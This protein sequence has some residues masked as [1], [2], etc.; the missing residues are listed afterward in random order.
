MT[1]IDP[2]RTLE[3]MRGEDLRAVVFDLGGVLI[4]YRGAAKL[5]D[6]RPDLTHEESWRLW[7]SSPAVRAFETGRLGASEFAASLTA[8]LRLTVSPADFLVEFTGWVVGPYAGTA[9]L[10]RRIP[11]H[12]TRATLSNI[13][14]VHW[15]RFESENDLYRLF[16]HHFPSH[17]TG[18]IK[19]DVE[20]FEH[21]ASAL[22]CEPGS[23]L[24][25]DDQPIN[26]R[27]AEKAGITAV[28]VQG[29]REAER[30]L[31]ELGI[32]DP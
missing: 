5:L 24:F 6:W 2:K 27:A 20:A 7:L 19:P 4:E 11:S 29:P 17:L 16:H 3:N 26:V 30:V 13:S 14:E 9:D 10:V 31:L 28:C 1:A 15:R 22:G 23:I 12:I 32:I 21:A 25:L 8:E 18:K